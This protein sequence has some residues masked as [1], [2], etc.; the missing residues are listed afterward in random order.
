MKAVLRYSQKVRIQDRYLVELEIHEVHRTTAQPLG[1][2]YRMICVDLATG[3]RVLMDNHQPKGPHVHI[4]AQE[5]PYQFID[6]QKLILDF[7][8]IVFA[9]MGIRL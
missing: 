8:E 9:R 1:L 3:A 6:E 5:A 2:K 7:E 4:D